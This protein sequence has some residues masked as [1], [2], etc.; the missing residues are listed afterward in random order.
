MTK[1][2][3]VSVDFQYVDDGGETR[4]SKSYRRPVTV[5]ESG[6]GLFGFIPPFGALVAALVAVPLVALGV[7]R[8]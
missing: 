3:P 4:L 7:R 5:V 2:Y 6:G 8:R 1:G